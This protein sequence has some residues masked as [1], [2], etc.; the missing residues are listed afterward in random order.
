MAG[1]RTGRLTNRLIDY[2]T[3]RVSDSLTTRLIDASC[4]EHFDHLT[5]RPIDYSDTLWRR[6]LVGR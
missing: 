2:L 1:L 5:H 3:D 6:R 4:L